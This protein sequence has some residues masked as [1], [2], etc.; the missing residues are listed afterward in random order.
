M[1]QE[2]F[3]R[4][5]KIYIG[6]DLPELAEP[7]RVATALSER[8]FQYVRQPIPPVVGDSPSLQS[9]LAGERVVLFFSAP[10]DGSAPGY[11]DVVGQVAEAFG[12]RVIDVDIDDP[13][14]GGMAQL[15][16]VM[17]TPCV[18]DASDRRRRLMGARS[19]DELMA[20]LD[21]DVPPDPTE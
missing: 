10:W 5:I 11:R 3:E 13:V 14:G 18:I 6:L 15:F 17:N 12:I 21:S 4:R 1:D 9:L 7:D 2:E 16:E 8:L 20:M 19:V